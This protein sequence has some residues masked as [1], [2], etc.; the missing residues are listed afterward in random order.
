MAVRSQATRRLLP[1]NKRIG[2]GVCKPWD[3]KVYGVLPIPNFTQLS[4]AYVYIN[5]DN[6]S[7]G[8]PITNT[9]NDLFVTYY[10][11]NFV[12]YTDA[13][14]ATITT[15]V[16]P[17][18][19]AF[20][21]TNGITNCVIN[22]PR[23]LVILGADAHFQIYFQQGVSQAIRDEKLQAFT[24]SLKQHANVSGGRTIYGGGANALVFPGIPSMNPLG[25]EE[26]Y[27]FGDYN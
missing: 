10:S 6:Q 2:Q 26:T 21:N 25:G 20:F 15:D 22:L 4:P 11:R 24:Q 3:Y 5:I 23:D 19:D 8:F 14:G 9:D 18:I 1:F 16:I 27:G 12:T 7:I 17:S 13:S